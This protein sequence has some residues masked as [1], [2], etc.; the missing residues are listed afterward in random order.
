M[1]GNAPLARAESSSTK[2][3]LLSSQVKEIAL[4][5]SELNSDG[6]RLYRGNSFYCRVV[7][8]WKSKVKERSLLLRSADPKTAASTDV[9]PC[10]SWVNFATLKTAFHSFSQTMLPR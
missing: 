7:V 8:W 2:M 6:F 9:G 5:C 1:E 3:S 4:Y 10:Q